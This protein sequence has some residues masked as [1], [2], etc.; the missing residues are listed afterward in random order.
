MKHALVTG[1]AGFIG[2]H[3]SEKLLQQGYRV[4]GV[5][6]FLS[7]YQKNIKLYH[8]SG[9]MNH[10]SFRFIQ[11]DLTQLDLNTLLKDV[12]VIFHQSA[13]PGVRTS[14]GK[15]FQD[16]TRHNILAT[17][18]LLEAAKFS[19]I[20]KFIY[21]SSSSIYGETEGLVSED[22]IPAPVSPYGVSKLS[23]EHLCRLYHT[24]FQVPAV[25]L[26]YFTVYGPRQRPD[27]AFHRFIRQALLQQAIVI[28]GDGKQTRDFTFVE[29]VVRAN[30]LA[31]EKG[32]DGE[33]YNIGGKNPV[34]LLKILQMIEEITGQSVQINYLDPIPGDPKHTRADIGKAEN[35]LGYR[36][37]WDIKDG[38]KEEVEYIRNLY[39]R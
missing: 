9:I 36:V 18:M 23:G 20:Q 13:M 1:C 16:Y 38:L 27:M 24:N 31:Y 29:D 4:T 7:N 33:I 17:Q 37:T 12:D 10:P 25:M 28:Y 35:E 34:S 8:L 26:R 11:G 21:A 15:Q 39:A 2:S 19:S 14:W 30:L 3:L 32:K 22:R 5:D 6:V